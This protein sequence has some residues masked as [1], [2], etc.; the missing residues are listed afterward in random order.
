M[1]I[2]TFLTAAISA[3]TLCA[4]LPALAVTVT[5]NAQG[6]VNSAGGTNGAYA[7]NNTFTGNEFG[8]RFDS[9]ASFNLSGLTGSFSSATLQLNV[10][11]Y[12]LAGP[13]TVSIH[14]V[15]SQPTGVSGYND[16]RSGA[17]YATFSASSNDLLSIALSSQ[18]VADI[19]AH[20]GDTFYIG[21]TNDTLNAQQ[22][23]SNV[24]TGAY[25][26]ESADGSY[27]PP[28]LILAAVPEPQTYALLLA[29][30]GAIGFKASRRRKS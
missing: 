26:N 17:T 13:F 16:T 27:A 9:F 1:N 4:T 18:A 22:S 23:I 15:S 20:L 10:A 30:L 3:A 5:S 19:N 21:F 28:Q 6:W 24:D 14:D 7:D 29:G 11:T 8:N 2:R 25:F 12:S